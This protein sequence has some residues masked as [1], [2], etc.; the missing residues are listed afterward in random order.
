MVCLVLLL[1]ACAAALQGYKT[2]SVWRL[3]AAASAQRGPRVARLFWLLAAFAPEET[4]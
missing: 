2:V 4:T 1:P 3:A